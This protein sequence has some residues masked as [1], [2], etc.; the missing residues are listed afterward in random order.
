MRCKGSHYL[1][2]SEEQQSWITP[3]PPCD[4]WTRGPLYMCGIWHVNTYG[5]AAG[6]GMSSNVC[7]DHVLI[8][9][10]LEGDAL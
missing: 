9:D 8:R 3:P 6:C 10:T 5:A 1:R 4:E 2:Y 7:V